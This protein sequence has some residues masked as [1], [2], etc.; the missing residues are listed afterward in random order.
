MATRPKTWVDPI[1]REIPIRGFNMRYYE[2][3]ADGPTAIFL[4]PSSGFGRMWDLVVRN[5]VGEFHIFAPDQRNH[6]DSDRPEGSQSGEEFAEDLHAFITTLGLDRVSLIGH[7]LGGR[8][9]QIYA[10]NHPEH[11]N[12][13]ICSGGPHYLSFFDDPEESASRAEGVRSMAE[14]TNVFPDRQAAEADIRA[15]NPHFSDEAV[16]VLIS[17]N[18]RDNPDG[19][20]SFKYDPKAVAEGLSHIPDKLNDYARRV[21]CPVLFLRGKDSTVLSRPQ[22]EEIAGLYRDCTIVDIDGRY[23]L[24]LENPEGAASAYRDFILGR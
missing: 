17:H 19:T 3:P 8:V 20:V 16:Q 24:Q 1:A 13:V 22:A 23:N 5:L 4:H 11:A 14:R 21:T 9:A 15:R 10:A 2:W 7:S 12:H 18:V 6:G